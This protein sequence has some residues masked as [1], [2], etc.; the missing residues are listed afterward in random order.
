[1]GSL[2]SDTRS[3]TETEIREKTAEPPLYKVVLYNDDFTTKLFVVEI[4]MVVFNKSMEEATQL[5]WHVHRHGRGVCG[6][7]PLEIA[8]TKAQTVIALA[9]ENGFPLKTSLEEE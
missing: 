8:E 4:L 3:K 5:M 6:I 9:R 1:M 2:Q 7:Y